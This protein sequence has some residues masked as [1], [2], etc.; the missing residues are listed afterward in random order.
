MDIQPIVIE[1][2]TD[3]RFLGVHIEKDLTWGMNTTKLVKKAQQILYFLRVLRKYNIAQSLLV[4]FYRSIIE[5]LLTYCFCVW[6]P[7]C[8]V[9]Y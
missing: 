6:F 7:S 5:S 1:R 9:E 3:F 2:V 8:T 4:S